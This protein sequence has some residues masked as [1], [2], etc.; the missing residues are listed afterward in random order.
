MLGAVML[1][2]TPDFFGPDSS[3]QQQAVDSQHI[4][5][6]LEA[7]SWHQQRAARGAQQSVMQ[8]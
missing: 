6:N 8:Q 5:S 4:L 3:K 1:Q 2:E 7:M